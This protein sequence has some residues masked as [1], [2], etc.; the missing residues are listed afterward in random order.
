VVSERTVDGLVLKLDLAE[1]VDGHRGVVAV[2]THLRAGAFQIPAE[3]CPASPFAVREPPT[4][5]CLT[6]L[7][8]NCSLGQLDEQAA[9]GR[10]IPRH[11]WSKP[12]LRPPRRPATSSSSATA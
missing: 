6:S 5:R 12:W 2:L 8:R 9:Q 11:P 3:E 7:N 10:P 4:V 1:S